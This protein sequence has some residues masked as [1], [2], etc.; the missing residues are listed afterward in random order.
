M[1]ILMLRMIRMFILMPRMIILM[2]Q[3]DGS[4]FMVHGSRLKAHGSWLMAKGGRSGPGARGSARLDNWV[5][6]I[7]GGSRSRT[8]TNAV[9]RSSLTA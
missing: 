9:T 6:L 5:C 4:W 7:L 1:I 2:D 3:D 8:T